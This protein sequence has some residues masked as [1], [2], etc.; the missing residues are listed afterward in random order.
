MSTHAE[1]PASSS[2]PR[3]RFPPQ[4][5][6][7]VGNEAAERFSFYGM[8]AI[9]TVFAT[10]LFMEVYPL[11]RVFAALLAPYTPES[12][13]LFG[14]ILAAQ[15]VAE[16]R[17]EMVFHLFVAAVYFTPLLGGYISD[18][19]W[20]KYHT[21]IRLSLVY[22]AGHAVLALWQSEAGFYL[23]LALIA[24]GAGGI[25]P[26]VSAHVGDQFTQATKSLLPKVFGIFYISINVG[27]VVASLVTPWTNAIWG[28][29]VAF[30]IPG[31]LM[32]VATLVF[33]L[34]RHQY[35]TV[36]PTGPRPDSPAKVMAVAL[37][38]GWKTAITT[39]G[40]VRVEDAK[41]VL[42]VAGILWPV[43]MFW[44]LFDQSSSSWVHLTER[45]NLH[46]LRASMFQ[47][48]NAMFILL[49]IP[50]FTGVIYPWFDR[51]G[52][53]TTPI[54][55]MTAGLFVTAL[56]F[57][58]IAV[59]GHWVAISPPESVSAFW[60]VVPYFL[61]TSGEILVS[62]TGLEFA[63]TQAPR[64]VKSSVMSIWFL[65]VAGGNLLAATVAGLNPFSSWLV[66]FLF[67]AA[68]TAITAGV[69]GLLG[70]SYKMAEYVETDKAS[71][72]ANA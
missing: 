61:L 14:H 15:K 11:D 37:L 41:A 27:S 65:T 67:W 38:R 40:E 25:K 8:R 3:L 20:G 43:I 2:G 50:L 58:S 70:R 55:R 52:L 51:R 21:I 57:V 71:A 64:S 42:R 7:I 46:G 47:A 29:E 66:R 32:A 5:K 22:V 34:G 26:C 48:V 10:V 33:W 49:L 63:Y 39:F 54:R 53:E 4:I 60:I 68:L 45:M 69:F 35:I 16:A 13:T 62:V 17:A 44:A 24:L 1:P 56:S 30:G 9:L 31:I 12:T 19:F 23:G 36:P 59:I 6:Y 72:E 28:P 18:R